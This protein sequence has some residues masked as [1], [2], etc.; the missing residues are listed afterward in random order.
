[1][2]AREKMD[3][4][5]VDADLTQDRYDSIYNGIDSYININYT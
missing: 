5:T 3:T 2:T 4:V 1:M